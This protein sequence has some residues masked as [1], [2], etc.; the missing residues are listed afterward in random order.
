MNCTFTYRKKN[1]RTKMKS[2]IQNKKYSLNKCEQEKE[3]NYTL[4]KTPQKIEFI[5]DLKE[6]SSQ[7][8][9]WDT[10]NESYRHTFSH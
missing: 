1:R 4:K 3:K 7:D 6:C 9:E 8:I 5:T 10:N 2:K